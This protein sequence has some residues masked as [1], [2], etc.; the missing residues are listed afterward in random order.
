M[1]T[2]NPLFGGLIFFALVPL[3]LLQAVES[4]D[5]IFSFPVTQLRP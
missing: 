5:D 1:S 3:N 4:N 2:P